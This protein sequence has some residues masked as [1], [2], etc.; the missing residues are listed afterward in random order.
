M[1]KKLQKG[2]SYLLPYYK[3]LIAQDLWQAHYQ[4]LSIISLKE[5]IELNVNTNMKRKK[6]QSCGIKY[7]HCNCFLDYTNFND[8]LTDYK[9]LYCNKSYNQKLDEKLKAQFF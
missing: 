1:E 7:K 6:C 9:C 8:D 5:F 3:L 4:I 2:I